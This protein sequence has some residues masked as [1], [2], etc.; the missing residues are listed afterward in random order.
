MAQAARRV[1]RAMPQI[2]VV[3][4]EEATVQKKLKVAAY[5]RVSTDKEEQE[6][7]FERQV[8]HYTNLIKSNPEWEFVR[9]YPDPGITGTKAEKRPEFMKMIEDCRAGKIE[10]IMVKSVSRF[11]RNTVDAL[12]YIR[13]LRDMNVSVQFESENIDTLTPGDEVLLT[14]L[15]A[16][17]EQESRTMSNNI[18]WAYQKKFEKG[19]VT[20]NTGLMLGYRKAGK[21]GD[22]RA[23]YEIVEE[24][25]EIIRRIY[26]EYLNG[27][28][29]T[30]I[31]HS[32]EAD[33]IRT[34]RGA[35][36]W[37]HNAITSILTNEKYTGNAYLGKTYKPDVLSKKR[38]R[39]DGEKAP[40]YYAENSHPAIIS[41]EVFNMVK[42]EMERRK[43]E[44]NKAVG[45]SRY[46]SKYPM[47][48]LLICGTCG[49][50]LRRHV[51][52]VGSGKMVPS[53][54][55][56]NRIVN[57]RAVCDSHH[58][59][60]DVLYATYHAAVEA[61][62]E[63][64][65]ALLEVIQTETEVEMQPRNKAAMDEVEQ[66]IIE[67]Q[68]R[69]LDLHKQKRAMK[70]SDAYYNAQ[71]NDYSQQLGALESRKQALQT[72]DA[73]YATVRM[74]LA[75]F[76]QHMQEGDA[77]DDRDGSIMKTLVE[78]IIV[79][80]DRIEVRFKCGATVEQKYVE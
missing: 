49:A 58:I 19:E 13:E 1:V 15:A 42:L 8:E 36:K 73:R 55:C 40:M 10:K 39:N 28:T 67:L 61:M 41:T 65:G 66:Q 80:D 44:K 43:E 54:G 6:D 47:S 21:D 11:A 14:I 24:E 72:A 4:L 22:G 33:G 25:A 30:Q 35:V 27:S 20:I 38:Y 59:N 32:L 78:A 50:R 26:R 3:Q 12:N 71:V 79:W 34:K 23:V 2:A 77:T 9:V 70:I 62:I 7:S 69:V 29:I 18:K 45:S 5:A 68:E 53:W 46:T 52:R 76:R 64:A 74:W 57:G 60:E 37:H 31:M 16:M 56:A 75:D 48:G 17:A 63:D 51:R